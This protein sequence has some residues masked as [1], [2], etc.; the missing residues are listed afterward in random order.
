MAYSTSNPPQRLSL[1][2][3][4]GFN[5]SEDSGTQANGACAGSIWL[6]KSTD[7]IGTV[8]G[9]GYFSNGVALGM[10]PGDLV[11]VIDSTTPHAYL[12][13]VG[14]LTAAGAATLTGTTLTTW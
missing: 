12:T 14:A 4:A 6:Y 8:N 9:A 13:T 7:V 3:L 2:A 1:G 10:Q 11:Y 5:T